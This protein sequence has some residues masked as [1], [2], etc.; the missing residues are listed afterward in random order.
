MRNEGHLRM[1]EG[2]MS[3]VWFLREEGKVMLYLKK[4]GKNIFKQENKQGRLCKKKGEILE[5]FEKRRM[6]D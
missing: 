2:G 4:I 1:K 3:M 6:E 5:D